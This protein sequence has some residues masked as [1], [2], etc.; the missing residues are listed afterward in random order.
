MG[1]KWYAESLEAQTPFYMM[2][3]RLILSLGETGALL[4]VDDSDGSPYGEGSRRVNGL[5]TA[6]PDW[7]SGSVGSVREWKGGSDRCGTLVG[8]DWGRE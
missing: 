6:L 3:R 4:F 2:F 5:G 1:K 7:G 8:A